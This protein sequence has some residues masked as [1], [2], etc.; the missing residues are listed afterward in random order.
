MNAFTWHKVDAVFGV[1]ALALGT[2]GAHGFRPQNPFYKE[3]RQTA[4]L[5]HLVHTGAL[6]TAPFTKHPHFFG[7]LLT[8]GILLFSGS[9]YTAALYEDRKYPMLA[10]VGGFAFIAVWE[11]H[12]IC[13]NDQNALRDSASQRWEVAGTRVLAGHFLWDLRQ[14]VTP[15]H[16]LITML[17]DPL[18]LFVSA[19]QFKHREE[20]ASLE[21]AADF[22]ASNMRGRLGW[23]DP[24]DIGFVRR[25]LGTDAANS[26]D[27]QLVYTKEQ[28]SAMASTA[29]EHLSNFWV[30]G[31]VEQYAGFVNVL[32]HTLDPELEHPRLWE[33]ASEVNNN[34]SPVHSRDVLD[35]IDPDLVREFNATLSFQWQVYDVALQLW[36][37]RCREVL[38]LQD[39]SSLCSVP[40]HKSSLS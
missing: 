38:P 28:S 20:T 31:V 34:G 3:V 2:Y 33:A 1:L 29:A 22:V 26:Y 19:K 21:A 37:S 18:E 6:V 14:Y 12:V 23:E 13:L 30:V 35:R 15:P 11:S 25:F 40:G 24:S 9:W 7:G 32:Q 39:H 36:D 27:P 17:R 16:L 5:Y 4:F 10:P 8:S